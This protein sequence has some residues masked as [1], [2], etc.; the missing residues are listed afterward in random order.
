ML[1]RRERL[2]PAAAFLGLAA[3][4]VLVLV[5]VTDAVDSGRRALEESAVAEVQAN[6][7]GQEAR[8]GGSLESL[9]TF[10]SDL[11]LDFEVGSE[12]DERE[13]SSIAELIEDAG[14]EIRTGFYLTDGSGTVTQGVRLS[15]REFGQPLDRPGFTE[16]LAALD[17]NPELGGGLLPVVPGGLTTE[18]PNYATVHAVRDADRSVLGTFVFEQEVTIDSPFNREINQLGRGDTGQLHVYDAAGTVIA[19]TDPSLV[20]RPVPD[21]SFLTLDPAL[22]RRDGRV[23]VFADILGGQW[24]IAFDQDADEFDEGLAGPLQRVGLI[25][26]VVFLVA[27]VISFIALTRRL[28]AAREEEARLRRLNET[29]EEFI[30]IVSH[31]L[32]TPVA[33]VLGFLQTTMDH[34]ESMTDTER[35]NA[36]RRSASNARRL[37][38]L[39]RDVLD[40][41]AV[42]TGRMSYA[43]DEADLREEVVVAVEAATALYPRLQVE[44]D[45][46]SDATPVTVDVDR[47]QQVL[48]NLIDNA[49]KVSPPDGRVTVSMWSDGGRAHVSVT[50]E[51]PGLA[52]ELRDRVFDKFVRGREAGVTGTGLGLY[53]TRQIIEAHGGHIRVEE[54][55]AGGAT[56]SF[57]LPLAAAAETSPVPG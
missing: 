48:T 31:E 55:P 11:D 49:A 45:V 41:Q 44:A 51:G 42:D 3:T 53:I 10:V 56:F 25:V 33:G 24:R 12:N 20:G 8:L 1:R 6:A 43:M 57:D 14:T 22:H 54:G 38:G 2:L 17:A 50:D 13:F 7:R 36:V 52:P 34:W 37:Q 40:S 21:Q 26:V 23:Q 16:L 27:G 35:L 30:S 15:R 18:Q 5:L 9:G 39:A 4:G 28:Q 46:R 32:R 47:I 19:S 29:Q